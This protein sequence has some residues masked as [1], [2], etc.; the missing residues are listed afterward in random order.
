[1][2]HSDESLAHKQIIPALLFIFSCQ[3]VAA[4][5][6]VTR[7]VMSTC[8]LQYECALIKMSYEFF[9]FLATTD[10]HCEI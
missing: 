6:H 1:M 7:R 2:R 4:D 3:P 10:E 9:G 8:E 5:D